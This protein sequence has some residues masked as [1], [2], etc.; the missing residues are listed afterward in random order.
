M[1]NA[2]TVLDALDRCD[3]SHTAW[4]IGCPYA[5]YKGCY[6]FLIHDARTIMLRSV[7]HVLSVEEIIESDFVYIEYH[8]NIIVDNSIE[9]CGVGSRCTEKEINLL[10]RDGFSFDFS[11]TFLSKDYNVTWRC[12]KFKP[13][14]EERKLAPW[15]APQ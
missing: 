15:S 6:R 10:L 12:W 8:Q 2:G 1:P 14:D 5:M 4:C 9:A 13:T 7:N 3:S 11:Q